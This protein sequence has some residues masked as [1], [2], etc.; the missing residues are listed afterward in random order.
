MISYRAAT[1]EDL[2]TLFSIE[3]ELYP[4]DAWSLDIFDS[5]F[6]GI[7]DTRYYVVAESDEIIGY[8][9]LFSPLA[10]EVADIQTMTVVKYEQGKGIGKALLKLLVI[11][12]LRR[13]AP[14]VLL[15][16][17]EDNASAI[18]LYQSA[19]FE[20]ISRRKNYY[21]PGIHAIIM[22]APSHLL[23]AWLTR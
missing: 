17:R 11:E 10:G 21:A 23:K 18:G 5:E 9:G 15:E 16:V 7:P 6:D 12:A 19:G 22:A 3:A 4:I 8:A 13:E 1:R 14:D 2:P 20:E